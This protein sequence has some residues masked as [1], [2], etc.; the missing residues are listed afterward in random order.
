[1]VTMQEKRVV[2]WQNHNH[3]NASQKTTTNSAWKWVINTTQAH[4]NWG[5]PTVFLILDLIQPI[6]IPDV[7]LCFYAERE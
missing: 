7:H 1:M 4:T 5:D 2:S 3:L 6:D